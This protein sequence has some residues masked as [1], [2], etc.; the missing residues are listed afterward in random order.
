MFAPGAVF[1]KVLTWGT[2]ECQHER[3]VL[4]TDQHRQGPCVYYGGWPTCLTQGVGR[5]CL[6][7]GKLTCLLL[8]RS[9][10]YLWGGGEASDVFTTREG[11]VYVCTGVTRFPRVGVF[12]SGGRAWCDTRLHRGWLPPRHT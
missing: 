12:T 6:L 5:L 1:T 9:R 7:E 11:G 2:C 8:G 3:P 10:Y 4:E